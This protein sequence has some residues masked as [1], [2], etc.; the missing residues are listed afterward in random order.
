MLTVH[1]ASCS[2]VF[3]FLDYCYGTSQTSRSPTGRNLMGWK[4][5]IKPTTKTINHSLFFYVA[6]CHASTPLC[7]L[8]QNV[9]AQHVVP[10]LLKEA[11]PSN[12]RGGVNFLENF[13]HKKPINFPWH[14]AIP[15]SNFMFCTIHLL[16]A[17]AQKFRCTIIY[18]YM[19]RHSDSLRAGRFGVLIPERVIFSPPVQTG[20][21]ACWASCTAGTGTFPRGQSGRGMGFTI[22]P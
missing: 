3:L 6:N 16:K 20:S 19:D 18:I 8:C 9:K 12:N 5:A 15:D 11:H 4:W 21:R 2:P 14:T 17:F 1:S 22:L 13:C 7:P 10:L